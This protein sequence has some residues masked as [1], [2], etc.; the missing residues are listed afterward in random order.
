MDG[1]SDACHKAHL[2]QVGETIGNEA[3]DI[4]KEFNAEFKGA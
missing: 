4:Q 2:E 3:E 1:C